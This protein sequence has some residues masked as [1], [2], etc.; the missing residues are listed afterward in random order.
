MTRAPATYWATRYA[1]WRTTIATPETF[2]IALL[3]KRSRS[4][5]GK[6]NA[7]VRRPI[8]AIRLPNSPIPVVAT[9]IYEQ[10]Q[11]ITDQP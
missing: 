9:T 10:I 3:S 7:P 4:K 6:V 1:M 11:S 2:P 5:S 8:S